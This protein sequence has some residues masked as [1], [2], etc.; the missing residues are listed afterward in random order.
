MDC[1]RFPIGSM[2]RILPNHA[3]A[4][5]AMYDRYYV[6]DAETEIA[7]VWDRINGW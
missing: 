3:C 5:G 4:T 1:G 7:A 6:V 2:V